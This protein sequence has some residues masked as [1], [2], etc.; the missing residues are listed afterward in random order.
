MR[1]ALHDADQGD[2]G[3]RTMKPKTV[4][5]PILFSTP[6][7]QSLLAGLK[8]QTR[9]IIPLTFFPGYNSEWSGYVPVFEYGRFFFAG[10]N[11]APATK[12]V[13]PRYQ[14]GDILWVRETWCP[15]ATVES[16]LDGTDLYVYKADCAVSYVPWK[17]RPSIYMPREAARIF[18]RVTDVRT[19]WLW[20]ITPEDVLAEGIR[21][22]CD[23]QEYRNDE[24]L[25]SAYR[26]LWDTLNA[27]RHG[28]IYAWIKNPWVWVYS[29]E[30]EEN[31]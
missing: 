24:M 6:M 17:W 26:D 12:P 28:G 10:G 20:D 19:D 31:R 25:L 11:G 14:V 5:K 16:R 2:Y 1:I 22:M 9:R 27:K 15:C 7:V 23:G 8:T 29:F 13:K 4:E 21:L 3:G 30:R 18:L